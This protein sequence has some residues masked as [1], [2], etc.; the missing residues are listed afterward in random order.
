MCLQIAVKRSSAAQV[1]AGRLGPQEALWPLIRLYDKF[2]HTTT[3][4]LLRSFKVGAGICRNCA[5]IVYLTDWGLW[6]LLKIC[7]DCCASLDQ[8]GQARLCLH[9]YLK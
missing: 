8:E 3:A 2:P 6:P 7:T 1:E 4:V 5:N 9:I